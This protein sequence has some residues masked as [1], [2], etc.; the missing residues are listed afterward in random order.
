MKLTTLLTVEYISYANRTLRPAERNMDNYSM[1]K[2]KLLGLKW[3]VTEKYRDCLL[4]IE[5]TVYTDNNTLSYLQTSAK[6][7]A[8]EIRWAAEL[9]QFQLHI[10]YLSG[11]SNINADA[12]GRKQYQELELH[13]VRFEEVWWS[14]E[15]V[16]CS[17]P[18]GSSKHAP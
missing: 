3:A 13:S 10:K 8:T 1:I 6:L 11:K 14:V 15:N 18:N 2:L 5:C 7:G 9:A 17:A 16:G 4:G 12:L